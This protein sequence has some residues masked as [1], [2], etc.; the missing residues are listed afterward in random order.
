MERA[1]EAVRHEFVATRGEA[2]WSVWRGFLPGSAAAPSMSL[3]AEALGVGE[4]SARS[5]VHRL[6]NRCRE[7]L[8]RELIGTVASPEDLD[9]EIAYLGRAL[10]G[11]R[12]AGHGRSPVAPMSKQPVER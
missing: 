4:G 6:Q 1:L 7:A 12:A 9:D 2:A 8:R 11:A 3:A 10:Q 5:E